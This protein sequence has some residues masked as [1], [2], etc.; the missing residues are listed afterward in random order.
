MSIKKL[1]LLAKNKILKAK[2]T[3]QKKKNEDLEKEI[4]VLKKQDQHD[5]LEKAALKARIINLENDPVEK[6][7]I[8][9]T[10]V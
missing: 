4:E 8:L 7:P 2:I 3:Q 5:D 9:V 10:R 1:P 6:I